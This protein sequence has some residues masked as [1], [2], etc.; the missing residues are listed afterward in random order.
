[1]SGERVVV[2]TSALID[3]AKGVEAVASA[4]VGQE[5][6]LSIITEIEFLAWPGMN[7]ERQTDA[8]AFL[9]E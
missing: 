8:H 1:M 9:K 2:D 6:H 3:Y 7:E 4:F 5:V